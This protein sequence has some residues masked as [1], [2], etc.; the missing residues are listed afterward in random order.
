MIL[1]QPHARFL[2]FYLVIGI[3]YKLKV[4][5]NFRALFGACSLSLI[6]THWLTDV[7]GTSNQVSDEPPHEH[8]LLAFC[9]RRMKTVLFHAYA[10]WIPG[11][12]S[13]GL[14]SGSGR[15]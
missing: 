5:Q 14:H 13:H 6:W 7:D 8:D 1:G 4:C 12:H 2:A 15:A 3:G 11:Y 10:P 9:H